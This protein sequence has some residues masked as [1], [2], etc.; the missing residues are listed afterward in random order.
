MDVLQ[1]APS[2]ANGSHKHRL[3]VGESNPTL[4]GFL[5]ATLRA[6]GHEVVAAGDNLLKTLAISLHPEFGSGEFDLVIS[7]G[8]LLGATELPTFSRLRGW[9]RIP[10]LVF[11]TAFE[12]DELDVKARQF[13]AVAALD[14]PLDI[15]KLREIVNSLLRYPA[16]EHG[17]IPANIPG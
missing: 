7:D 2:N 6:D 16:G 10:P 15:D 8:R 9:A 5:L 12:D 14:M 3:L 4:R 11:I 13:G 17:S 1:S